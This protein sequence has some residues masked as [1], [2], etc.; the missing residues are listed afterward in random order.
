MTEKK[1]SIFK[2]IFGDASKSI[3]VDH[4]KSDLPSSDD[5]YEIAWRN[6]YMA[7]RIKH[8]EKIIRKQ[9]RENYPGLPVFNLPDDVSSGSVGHLKALSKKLQTHL[10]ILESAT[11]QAKT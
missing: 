8:L 7:A 3:G 5:A 10:E 6:K 1:P 2:R 9:G 11:G 4:P